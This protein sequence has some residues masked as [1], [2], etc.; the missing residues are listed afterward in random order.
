MTIRRF[1]AVM[2]IFAL[3]AYATNVKP[4]LWEVNTKMGGA[5]MDKAMAAMQAQL[6]SMPAEQ[7][8]MME[9][10]MARQ[11][12]NFSGMSGGGINV[13]MCMTKEMAARN[14][15]PVQNQGT[16]TTTQSPIA[17][18]R[19]KFSFTCK[20]PP[21][22]GSGEVSFTGDT[23]YSMKMKATSTVQG[24]PQDIDMAATGKWIGA[25]CGNIKPIAVPDAAK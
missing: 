21:S 5:E 15:L 20:N 24:K 7:R 12:V 18:G 11:G 4:G 23:S 25:D 1:L 9:D 22:S 2:A 17:G 14:Q 10:M 13:K 8:K 19:M 16:C 3:P 6:A